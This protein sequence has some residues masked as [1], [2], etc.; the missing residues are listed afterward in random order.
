MVDLA[1]DGG[2][3][4]NQRRITNNRDGVLPGRRD[5]DAPA[6]AVRADMRAA[7]RGDGGA[8]DVRRT[9][10][11]FFNAVSSAGQAKTQN[12][13]DGFRREAAQ[14][15][16]AAQAGEEITPE[17]AKSLAYTE[18]FYKVRAE[19]RFNEFSAETKVM[20][21]EALARGDAPDEVEG[22]V[23]ERFKEFSSDVLDSI[24][25][26]SAQR[27]TAGRLSGLGG[28][29][30]A[31]ISTTIRERTRAEFVT[32]A[33]GNIGAAIRSGQ[34]IDFEA[35]VATLRQG[36]IDPAAAKKAVME[37]VMTVALDRDDP[38]PELLE[39]LL[40]STQADGK[41]PSLS[42]SEQLQIQDRITQARSLQ[43]QVEREERE[44]KR[45][46]LMDAWLPRVLDGDIVDDEIIQAGRDGIL[47]PQEVVQY[48]G[49]TDNLR[50]A[51][52]EGHEDTDFVLEVTR[53]AAM[54]NPPSN[55]QVLA[56]ANQGRFGSG[57]AGQRAAI[58]FLQDA[59]GGRGGSG[60][61]GG[62]GR[63]GGGSGGGALGITAK[64]EATRNVSTARSF[65]WD[66]TQPEAPSQ[67][68]GE[69]LVLQDREFNR[70]VRSGEDPFTVARSLVQRNRDVI[71]RDQRPSTNAPARGGGA[72]TV[73]RG[74]DGRLQVQR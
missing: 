11:G 27:D 55:A 22:L 43:A 65:L 29:L 19:S 44:A 15:S 17:R 49:L 51:P 72:A 66:Q 31:S 56:W 2:R 42:A 35:N 38:N 36:G 62:G 13:M 39:Q 59:G 34:P 25:T 21:E 24:P 1:L 16:L 32:T 26:A 73:V 61:G 53:R 63:G 48:I 4:T 46:A 41:T 30:E 37:S 50:D 45:D 33:Q 10:D 18:A 9:L 3:R 70:R 71:A 40:E 20:V 52:H 68:Q 69:M 60:G 57:R 28:D 64:T 58:R 47:E 8:D 74:P 12:D 54:G 7:T 14:G 6:V 5:T 23:L 67:Y